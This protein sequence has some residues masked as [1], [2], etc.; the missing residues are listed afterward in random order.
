[1]SKNSEDKAPEETTYFPILDANSLLNFL[2]SYI[3]IYFG[4]YISPWTYGLDRALTGRI[5]LGPEERYRG[6]MENCHSS[7]HLCLLGSFFPV[8]AIPEIARDQGAEPEG[9]YRGLIQ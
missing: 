1:M 3:F 2:D 6:C 4:S 7:R 5:S 9:R 8:L